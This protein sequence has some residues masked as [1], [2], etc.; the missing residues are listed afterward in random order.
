[1]A[2]ALLLLLLPRAGSVPLAL[3]LG[4]APRLSVG[5]GVALAVGVGVA[6]ALGVQ[7]AVALPLLE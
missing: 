3:A 2:P 1:V 5:E 7:V 4:L 6:V